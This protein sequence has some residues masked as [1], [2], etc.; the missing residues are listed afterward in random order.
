MGKEMQIED[1]ILSKLGIVKKPIRWLSAVVSARTREI[2]YG[3]AEDEEE[4]AK[5]LCT[6]S[7]M[8]ALFQTHMAKQS[9]KFLLAY[10]IIQ[11]VYLVCFFI[12]ATLHKL[13]YV[14][15]VAD[16]VMLILHFVVVIIHVAQRRRRKT[17]E[18]FSLP[19]LML[20]A[21]LMV[22]A[23]L[24]ALSDPVVESQANRILHVAKL[25]DALGGIPSLDGP[26]LHH[27]YKSNSV[28]QFHVMYMSL[29]VLSFS[30]A[31]VVTPICMVIY[32][33]LVLSCYRAYYA[34]SEHVQQVVW[35][36]VFTDIVVMI[37]TLCCAVLAKRMLE[38][39][40]RS[41]FSALQSEKRKALEEKVM[42]CKVEF[43]N[44]NL[45][46][47]LSSSLA[48]DHLRARNSAKMPSK[49]QSLLKMKPKAPSVK[50]APPVVISRSVKGK[51]AQV[52]EALPSVLQGCQGDGD[53]LPAEAC[54][55]VD[56]HMDPQPLHSLHAG[57]RV[58]CYDN[59][60]QCVKHVEVVQATVTQEESPKDFVT[61]Q[62]AD[63]T[64]LEMTSDHHVECYSGMGGGM[65]KC[66]PAVNLQE[67]EDSLIVLNI[68][69][70]E[71]V[72]V[73]RSSRDEDDGRRRWVSLN[74]QQPQRHSVFVANHQSI[75]GRYPTTM[76]VGSADLKPTLAQV[77]H[78]F[79]HIQD[80]EHS[81]SRKTNS[82]PPT[83]SHN[84]HSPAV[85][86]QLS[87][88]NSLENGTPL[89][90]SLPVV[91]ADFRPDMS[92][93]SSDVEICGI[94]DIEAQSELVRDD[95]EDQSEIFNDINGDA[96]SSQ[97]SI[98]PG[99]RIPSSSSWRRRQR[100]RQRRRGGRSQPNLQD[101]QASSDRGQ[102]VDG[103]EVV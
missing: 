37:L 63:D 3:C 73:S 71:V 90:S 101:V 87:S 15:L 45:Q 28:F 14:P 74:V 12:A 50:S 30:S 66:I 89:F 81:S 18:N 44:S 27:P 35:E 16:C 85:S 58:L 47:M 29:F 61:V 2:I 64:L 84:L 79:V 103:L 33:F 13:N 48:A 22:D 24:F 60:L 8:E 62:L 43:E 52:H 31:V 93:I 11:L 26:V 99:S 65:R 80:S 77:R 68:K 59:L 88:M 82:A 34:E 56:H 17:I 1:R 32:S 7:N 20:D 98:L 9:Q 55:W 92:Q 4:D 23:L 6:M 41:F 36:D 57:D 76:A 72:K 5:A 78:T 67:G 54:V 75:H 83:Y 21:A 53:C 49:F 69:P 70:Q 39:L 25:F 102:G 19:R 38:Q 46:D 10:I 95:Y 40:Q 97:G 51:D 100:Q 42:R 91:L 94:N 86:V 96:L